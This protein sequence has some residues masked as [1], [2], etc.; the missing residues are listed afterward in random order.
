[1][2][3]SKRKFIA[4]E[5]PNIAIDIKNKR[6]Q[7]NNLIDEETR[8]SAI[9]TKSDSFEVLE[10][11]IGEL[12]L[13]YQKMG[14]YEH[15]LSQLKTVEDKLYTLKQTL[16]KIDDGLFSDEF[17]EKIKQQVNKFN[18]HFSAVSYELYG[19]KYALKA[20]QK[21]LKN[22][23]RLYEFTAFNANFSSGKKQGEISCFDIAYTL[24]AD[25]E[26]IPCM[27][28]LLNDKK[29]LMHDNQ[30]VM[31]GKLVKSK[32]I[33]FVASILKDKL[34]DELKKDEYIIVKLSQNDKL[35]RIESNK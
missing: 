16:N 31:I 2:V 8:L 28:F 10:T 20:D 5:L 14:E 18:R 33:Q 13:K 34:P 6:S 35:Y 27:H 1:M 12:N 15:I 29:E 4:Q 32:N 25:E 17:A 21:T 23:Q 26:N 3:E 24:F 9:V 7:L 22:G 19:E 30:L 11:M